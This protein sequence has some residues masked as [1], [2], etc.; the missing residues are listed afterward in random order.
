MRTLQL[1]NY[2]GW[3]HKL[4]VLSLT[5]IEIPQAAQAA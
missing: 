5:V 3:T 2:C 1:T 4:T